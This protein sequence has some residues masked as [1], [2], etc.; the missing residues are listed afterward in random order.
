MQTWT[1]RQCWPPEGLPD[2][3]RISPR[4]AGV[5]KIYME[6][7]FMRFDCDVYLQP[8]RSWWSLPDPPSPPLSPVPEPNSQTKVQAKFLLQKLKPIF[9]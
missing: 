1:E 6:K 4:P 5:G 3:R 2:Q 9:I 8:D 7:M